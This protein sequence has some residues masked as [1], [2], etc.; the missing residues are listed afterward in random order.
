MY[1]VR[2]VLLISVCRPLLLVIDLQAT[3]RVRAPPIINTGHM[4]AVGL[5]ALVNR[6]RICQ[7]SRHLSF[8]Q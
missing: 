8:V 5:F 2:F 6:P 3:E 4:P 1:F 7:N